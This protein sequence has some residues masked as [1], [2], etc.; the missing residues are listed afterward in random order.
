MSGLPAEPSRDGG[1]E[2]RRAEG[3]GNHGGTIVLMPVVA[4]EEIVN[5]VLIAIA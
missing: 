4:D 5:F 2:R 3:W 1:L